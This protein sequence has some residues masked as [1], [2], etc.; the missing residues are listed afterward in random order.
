MLTQRK[1]KGSDDKDIHTGEIKVGP[2]KSRACFKVVSVVPCFTIF[3]D[4]TSNLRLF[5]EV[6]GRYGAIAFP[7]GG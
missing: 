7:E 5:P 6:T 3:R 4:S 1:R 2:L